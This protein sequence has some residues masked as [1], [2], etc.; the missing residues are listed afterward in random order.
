MIGHSCS[1]ACMYVQVQL[2]CHVYTQEFAYDS[3][4]RAGG[5][6]NFRPGEVDD[7]ASEGSRALLSKFDLVEVRTV[8][9]VV[10]SCCAC[11]L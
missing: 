8:Y 1:A 3:S 6:S 7:G 9:V 11:Q 2:S 5:S 4:Y 10:K